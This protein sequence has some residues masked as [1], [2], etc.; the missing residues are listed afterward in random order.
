MDIDIDFP[1]TFDPA[2]IFIGTKASMVNNNELKKHP[3]GFYFQ[4]I[5]VDPITGL[6]AI[7]YKK[8][9]ALGFFKIDCLHISLL[10]DFASKDEI[11]TLLQ[12]EPDWSMLENQHVVEKLSQLKNHFDVVHIIQP[13]NIEDLCDCISIFRPGKQHLLQFYRQNKKVIRE[14]LYK[15]TDEYYFKRSHALAYAMNV[16]LQMHLIKAGII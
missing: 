7:P 5:P 2:D 11:R 10:D 6:A 15:K 3:A 13:K 8:A 4:D 12:I 9:E 16:V 1:T 14:E